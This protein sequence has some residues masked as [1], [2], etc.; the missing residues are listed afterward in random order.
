L[1]LRAAYGRYVAL[2]EGFVEAGIEITLPLFDRNQ[3]RIEEARASV[4][5]AEQDARRIESELGVQLELA[6][7][8]CSLAARQLTVHEETIEPAAARGLAQARAG[9]RAGRVAFLELLD[10]QRTFAR[11]RTR[12]L[13]LRRDLGLA[14]AELASLAGLE[15]YQD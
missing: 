15:P 6:N 4:Q 5:R 8:R 12:T 11:A 1:G 9:Y 7:Q 2:D 3:G 14:T 10:A 13:E